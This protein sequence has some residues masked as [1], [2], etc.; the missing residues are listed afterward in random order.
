MKL[1]ERAENKSIRIAEEWNRPASRSVG[2]T[3]VSVC[4][5]MLGR[6]EPQK[7]EDSILD[8]NRNDL[9]RSVV[10]NCVLLDL[11]T[12]GHIHSLKSQW[13]LWGANSFASAVAVMMSAMV[14]AIR[15]GGFGVW[16]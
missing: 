6:M 8:S 7:K 2:G 3:A 11:H 10:K 14:I 5:C 13:H 12:F 1:M 15:L 9:L 4:R 16:K